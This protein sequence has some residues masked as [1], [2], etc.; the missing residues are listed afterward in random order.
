LPKRREFVP[1]VLSVRRIDLLNIPVGKMFYLNCL[2]ETVLFE[3]VLLKSFYLKLFYLK[4]F[5]LKSFY[6]EIILF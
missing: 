6:F 3:I 5:Y 2:F 1:L 4:L